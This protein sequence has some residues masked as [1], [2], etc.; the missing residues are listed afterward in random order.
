MFT[1]GSVTSADGTSIS[2]RQLGR[3]PALVLVHGAMQAAQSFMVLAGALAEAFTVYVPDRRGR[4]SSGPV[5]DRYGIDRERE[6]LQA[7]IAKTGCQDV[8]GLSSGALIAMT[9][10]LH[11]PAIQRL[12]LY[13]PPFPIGDPAAISF[14]PRYE[15]E[16]ASGDLAAAM[17]TVLRGTGDVSLL[18]RVPRFVM[19]P[20]LRAAIFADRR[21]SRPPDV[22]VASLIPTM[23]NDISLVRELDGRLDDYK[24]LTARVLLLGGATSHPTL[25]RALDAI[26]AVLPAAARVELPGVGHIAADNRGNPELVARELR[27]FFRG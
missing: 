27:R 11:E 20:L 5:G 8:F 18:A 13:E 2:Y 24:M 16:V 26:A 3:G 4:A 19:E 22:P 23:R 9:T 17:T 1:T 21:K 15:R 14:A 6:D 12:A 25:G 7:L 10:A